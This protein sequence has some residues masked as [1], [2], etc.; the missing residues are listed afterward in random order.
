MVWAGEGPTGRARAGITIAPTGGAPVIS[1]RGYS[2]D[3]DVDRTL[4]ELRTAAWQAGNAA[5]A[6]NY[7]YIQAHGPLTKAAAEEA[8]ENAIGLDDIIDALFYASAV[9][10]L[11]PFPAT[12]IG[13]RIGMLATSAGRAAA[14]G[15]SFQTARYINQLSREVNR[16]WGLASAYRRNVAPAI[17]NYRRW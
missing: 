4:E 2:T 7:S 5:L 8:K 9:A 11:I 15:N 17:K 13:G 16:G 10:S 12:Q 1:P 3:V 6:S 14:A